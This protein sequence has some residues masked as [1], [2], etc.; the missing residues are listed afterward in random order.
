MSVSEPGG[1]VQDV[2]VLRRVGYGLAALGTAAVLMRVVAPGPLWSGV[3]LIAAVLGLA[4]VV[5][6]PEAFETRYRGGAPR[7]NPLVGAP[8]FFLFIIAITD[9]V[10]DLT[11]PVAGAAVGAAVLLMVSMRGLDRPGL[12]SPLTYQIM[13]AVFG[14]AI[15]YGAVVALDVDYD[16]SPPAVLSEPVLGK[17]ITTSRS[18]V[19]YHLRVPP[20]AG[21]KAASSLNVDGV[22]YRALKPGDRVCV[23]E[24][25][26]AIGLP[27]VTA[28]LCNA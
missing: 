22:T 3:L 28:R 6:A 8:A 18:R 11:L 10:D 13:A 16:G 21:R 20:F 15:G 7:L 19:S 17:S 5:R 25:H 2:G 23:L 1:V 12:S 14:A 26:G 4:I 24:H 27:W 9:Q